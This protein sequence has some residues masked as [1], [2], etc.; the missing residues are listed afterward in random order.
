[1]SRDDFFEAQTLFQNLIIGGINVA[2]LATGEVYS[3]DRLRKQPYDIMYIVAEQI[4]ANQE[5]ARKSQLI[6]DAKAR[7]KKR[8]SEHG[9]EGKPYTRQTPAWITWSDE[10]KRYELIPERAAL[11]K[12][13]FDRMAAGDGLTRIARDLNERAVPTW[14]RSGKQRT[15]DH[16]RTSY[17]R[18][19]LT[20]TAPIG[21]FTPHTTAH[22]DTTRAR[23][24]EPME[25]VENLFPAAIDADT[26]WRVNRKL[27]TK[28]A[29][30]R[31]ARQPPKSIV[32][33]IAFCATCGHAMTRVS[34]GDYVYLVCSRA[35]MK[36]EGCRYLAVRYEAVE[37][38]LRTNAHRLI[39]EAPR[40]KSTADLETQID[41][42]QA[43]AD[44]AEQMTFDLAEL[45]AHERSPAARGRL[46]DMEQQ[47]KDLQKQLRELRGQRETLTTASVKD[48]LKAVQ[49]ALAGK[50][51]V[52]EVNKVL[53]DAIRRIVIDPE[54]G[55]LWIR[56]HHSEDVQ[57]I[58]CVT[59]HMSFEDFRETVPPMRALF[60]ERPSVN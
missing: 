44:A 50:V 27:S 37:K 33:G 60:P 16:W 43:N 8:L 14:S 17:I 30:G 6:G 40:G 59:R 32:S 49:H 39:K 1:M 31:N 48:R 25:P 52:P 36:A 45:A 42:L 10:D 5:S 26:Y 29:R 22:D 18:K 19:V 15:A 7:K 41:R 9:L 11:V 46:R 3:H 47:L 20:S 54:Q 51:D 35:N 21:T 34:K 53:R 58:L 55:H 2:V 28:A 23:R 12:E 56:W 57:D 38:A 24:D 13:M 4:R